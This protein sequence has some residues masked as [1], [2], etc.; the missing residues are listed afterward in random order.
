VSN[1]FPAQPSGL[2][3]ASVEYNASF[4]AASEPTAPSA[5]AFDGTAVMFGGAF[6]SLGG[7][8]AVVYTFDIPGVAGSFDQTTAEADIAKV[9][10]DACQVLADLTGIP[11]ATVQSA[12]SVS[13]RW[14][15][16]DAA[17]NQA[18]FTDTMTYP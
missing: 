14:T 16:R 2:P 4:G 17:G 3:L 8:S 15:W 7:G 13:R 18:V 9:L 1:S 6:N 5:L 11:L 12:V 10:T